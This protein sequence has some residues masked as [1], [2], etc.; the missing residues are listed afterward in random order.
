[1]Q[2]LI[3]MLAAPSSNLAFPEFTPEI[4]ENDDRVR[5]ISETL[6]RTLSNNMR[7]NHQP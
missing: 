2:T 4:A 7:E 5:A 6:R 3:P 1:M